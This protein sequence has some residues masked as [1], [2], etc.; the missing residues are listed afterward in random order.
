M[1]P[2]L[3]HLQSELSVTH[4][5]YISFNYSCDKMFLQTIDIDDDATEESSSHQLNY[6][7]YAKAALPT[8]SVNV[9]LSSDVPAASVS[10]TSAAGVSLDEM[11]TI[12]N[13]LPV[14]P[15]FML[16]KNVSQVWGK[17]PEPAQPA[18]PFSTPSAL[19]VSSQPVQVLQ[20]A[21]TVAYDQSPPAVPEPEAPRA[22]TEKEKMA[23]ALFGGFGGGGGSK[24]GRRTSSSIKSTGYAAPLVA[25]GAAEK[26]ISSSVAEPLVQDIRA[27]NLLDLISLDQDPIPSY[28]SDAINLLADLTPPT[29]ITAPASTAVARQDVF[30]VFDNVLASTSQA[31]PIP[32]VVGS[33]F[34]IPSMPSISVLHPLPMKT[35]D[36]GAR[37]SS[38]SCEAKQTAACGIK[39]LAQLRNLI[40][41]YNGSAFIGHVESIQNTNEVFKANMSYH[42]LI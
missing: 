33:I 8:N 12:G 26:K 28:R 41:N 20:S 18:V 36:F 14:H 22:Q 25:S 40:E 11:G 7:P 4:S 2:I 16:G 19:P 31:M 9:R 37:W 24:A 15:S 35:T 42:N 17:K 34:T 29:L 5:I 27:D 39:S 13:A 3:I 1:E 23:A 32:P 21:P 30:D 10:Q 38:V 6:A